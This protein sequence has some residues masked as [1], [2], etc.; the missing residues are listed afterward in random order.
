MRNMTE[1]SDEQLIN[2]FVEGDNRAFEVLY[3][4][5]NECVCS[6][7]M[8]L[9]KNA[10]LADDFVQDTY[11]KVM[12]NLKNGRYMHRGK[13]SNWMMSVAHNVVFDYYRS[14]SAQCPCSNI[15]DEEAQLYRSEAIVDDSYAE[16]IER[17]ERFVS[18]EKAVARLSDE[19]REVI[20]LHYFKG[21]SFK[22]IASSKRISINTALGRMRYAV[23]NLRKTLGKVAMM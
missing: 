5:H 10:T 12:L 22:D 14:L 7:V 15:E 9:V 6:Y 19:Q 4:R 8:S 11:I 21:E 17:E 13:F 23:L 16:R 2:M 3:A 20:S 1:L 18:L